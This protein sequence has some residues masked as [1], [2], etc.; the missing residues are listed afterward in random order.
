MSQAGKTN[1]EII[2]TH[3]QIFACSSGVARNTTA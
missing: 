3:I 2:I 1:R